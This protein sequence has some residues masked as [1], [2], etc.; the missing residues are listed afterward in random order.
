MGQKPHP[1]TV[2]VLDTTDGAFLISGDDC[3]GVGG[4]GRQ[5]TCAG[6]FRCKVP[7]IYQF[8]L[9]GSQILTNKATSQFTGWIKLNG[10]AYTGSYS[11]A[12]VLPSETGKLAQLNIVLLKKLKAEGRLNTVSVTVLIDL[13]I[14][15]EISTMFVR[16]YG[17]DTLATGQKTRQ[18][19]SSFRS[20]INIS[21]FI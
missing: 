19:F 17:D 3:Y 14:D 13:N 2:P 12:A 6:T 15:D 18:K 21:S 5:S 4:R 10:K 16:Y 7:G 11:N 1:F 9:T 8:M 20:V